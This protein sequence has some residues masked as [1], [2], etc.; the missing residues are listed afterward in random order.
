MF[1]DLMENIDVLLDLIEL[2]GLS[3]SAHVSLY[4]SQDK[5]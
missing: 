5:D 2:S 1:L 4:A 3:T